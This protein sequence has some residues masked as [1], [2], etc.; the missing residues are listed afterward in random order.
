MKALSDFKPA[1]QIIEG[2]AFARSSDVA[3]FRQA[4]L[5]LPAPKDFEDNT[6][7]PDAPDLEL[8]FSPMTW[9]QHTCGSFSEGY[10]FSL[11]DVLLR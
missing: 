3:L 7:G 4:G 11:H 10:H 5:T 1:L 6:T 9:L 2:I 8:W